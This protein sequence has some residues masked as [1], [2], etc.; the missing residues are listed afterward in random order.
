MNNSV[1]FSTFCV[2]QLSHLPS[3]ITFSSLQKEILYPLISC[4]LFFF[5]SNPWRSISILSIDFP[6][7]ILHISGIIQCDTESSP[8]IMSLMFI[9]ISVCYHHS[10]YSRMLFYYAFVNAFIDDGH[11]GSFCLLA[12]VNSGALNMY[13]CIWVLVFSFGKYVYLWKLIYRFSTFH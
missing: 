4:F 12:I 9:H 10:F 1:A 2:L 8:S 13:L 11:L 5:P 7:L 6:F 3:S